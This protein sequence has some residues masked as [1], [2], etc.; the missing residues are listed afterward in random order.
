MNVKCGSYGVLKLSSGASN[1]NGT[2]IGLSDGM[3]ITSNTPVAGYFLETRD[4]NAGDY[5]LFNVREN[6]EFN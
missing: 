5:V 1:H 2:I 6:Y 3:V 4:V